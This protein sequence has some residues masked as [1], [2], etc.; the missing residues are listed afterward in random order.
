[1]MPARDETG[2]ADADPRRDAELVRRARRGEAP[3]F[4]ELVR[5]HYTLAFSVAL[6]VLG[7]RP[8]AEDVC[9]DAL[10]RA[11]ERLD[12]CQQPERFQFWLCA[13][14]RNLARNARDRHRTIAL[15]DEPLTGPDSSSR[16]AELADLRL[17]LE[18]ALAALT[19][20]QREVLLLHD[21]AGW[22]HPLIAESLG[23]S[24]GMSRQHLLAARRRLR[25][26]LGHQLLEDYRLD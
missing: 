3:A 11:G 25:A 16:P 6:A 10:I 5:R 8:D 17:R 21:L 9:H 12:D 22:T 24:A 23:T 26:V 1:M 4:E 15:E 7:N 14:V 2:H 20:T 13:I 18:R 19:D